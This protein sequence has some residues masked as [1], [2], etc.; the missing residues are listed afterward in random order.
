MIS[1]IGSVF[2]SMSTTQIII[3]AKKKPLICIVGCLS[4]TLVQRQTPRGG[5]LDTDYS[6]E[7]L[8]LAKKQ[9]LAGAAS[10]MTL[11][12]QNYRMRRLAF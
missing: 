6:T 12:Q 9:I 5:I 10:Q 7:V 8:M 2:D 11:Y 4:A 3:G 1:V